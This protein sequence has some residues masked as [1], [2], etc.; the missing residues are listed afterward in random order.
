MPKTSSKVWRVAATFVIAALAMWAFGACDGGGTASTSGV[1]LASLLAIL[2][3]PGDQS[4]A[5]LTDLDAA[6]KAVPNPTEAPPKEL[7]DAVGTRFANLA[8]A[9]VPITS[10]L[11]AGLPQV[12]AACKNL[13]LAKIACSDIRAVAQVDVAPPRL[14]SAAR[15]KF[16]PQA[17]A[18]ALKSCAGCVPPLRQTVYKGVTYFAWTDDPLTMSPTD[19]LKPPVFDALGRA[20]LTAVTADTIFQAR[21][22]D[23]MKALI[24]AYKG[25]K[26][27][28]QDKR[29]TAV[30]QALEGGGAYSAYITGQT[31]DVKNPDPAGAIA[32]TDAERLAWSSSGPLLKPYELLGIGQGQS[33]A[34]PMLLLALYHANAAN[35]KTSAT[36]L[37]ERISNIESVFTH[38]RWIEQFTS[39]DISATGQ[40]MFARLGGPGGRIFT[41]FFFVRDPLLLHE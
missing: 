22:E 20:P 8:F 31:Q 39:V 33:G 28:A 24:D 35:A 5:Y 38:K 14:V 25:G 27:L 12:V 19:R 26:S 34:D 6:A 17:F 40:V 10:F 41:S 15:G 29:M 18:E 7:L 32:G 1:G 3:D 9:R 21:S 36:Q 11:G 13:A 2:P 16:D 23:D 4:G 30:A 37:K